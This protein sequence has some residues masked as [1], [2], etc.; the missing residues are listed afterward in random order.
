MFYYFRNSE[1]KIDI[2]IENIEWKIKTIQSFA[3]Y[4][5]S[6]NSTTLNKPLKIPS[7]L[8]FE[9]KTLAPN[10]GIVYDLNYIS[11]RV[12]AEFINCLFKVVEFLLI[13]KSGRNWI[14]NSFRN[15]LFDYIGQS[16]IRTSHFF[17][18]VTKPQSI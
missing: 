18:S 6:R 14:V 16:N 5:V 11:N 1:M 13:L 12:G 15:S 9:S 17:A 8:G 2:T 3:D 10:R 4:N 7:S